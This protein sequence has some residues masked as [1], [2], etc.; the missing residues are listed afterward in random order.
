MSEATGPQEKRSR[1]VFKDYQLGDL[2]H[3]YQKK[4]KADQALN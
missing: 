2:E 4:A 1:V 3:T